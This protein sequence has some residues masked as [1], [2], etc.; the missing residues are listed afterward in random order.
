LGKILVAHT[1][2][3]RYSRAEEV[4]NSITHGVA[5]ALS[6]AGLIVLIVLAS[7]QRDPWRIVSFSVYGGSLV[8][9]F[10]T[11]T[12]YH[13]IPKQSVKRFM[14]RL[15]HA[16]IYLL[17]AGTYTPILL[18]SLR[19]TLG[20]TLLGIVWGLALV[21]IACEVLHVKYLKILSMVLYL[22]M[23]WLA[24]LAFKPTLAAITPGGFTLL[25]L[26]GVLYTIGVVFYLWRRLPFNHAIWHM[27]VV[28]AS[29]CHFFAVAF[30]VLPTH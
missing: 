14:R 4:T 17:I 16:T 3:P 18:V 30:Y 8:L 1:E 23:G 22:G 13:S 20:W 5:G 29:V 9:L 12:L 15:D 10:L 28:V 26:G 6:I 25:A 24:V 2:A 21:G 11:S 7:L 19:G 27:F